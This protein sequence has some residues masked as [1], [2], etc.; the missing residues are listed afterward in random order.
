M[1]TATDIKARFPGAFTSI[2]DALLETVI[3]EASLE[4][5]EGLWGTYYDTGLLYLSAHIASMSA[6][7]AS[8]ASVSGPVSS[9]RIG[10]V[11]ISYATPQGGVSA[12]NSTSYGQRFL[13]LR[14]RI[15]CGPLCVANDRSSV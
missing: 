8:S 5:S 7:G 10:D 6:M 2:S 9:K 1:I 12:I 11:S 4:I 3:V 15:Q 14:K 13:E